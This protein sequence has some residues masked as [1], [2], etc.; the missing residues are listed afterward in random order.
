MHF[1]DRVTDYAQRSCCSCHLEV[2]APPAGY[3][4]SRG[5][6]VYAVDALGAGRILE[7]NDDLVAIMSR[8]CPR[9][10]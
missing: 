2:H 7:R 5:H 3:R 8:T 1:G 6:L 10:T 4:A 9:S